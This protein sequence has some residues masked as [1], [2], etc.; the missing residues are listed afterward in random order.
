MKWT[1]NLEFNL[2]KNRNNRNPHLLHPFVRRGMEAMLKELEDRGFAPLMFEGWRHPERQ[3]KMKWASNGVVTRAKEWVSSHQFGLA[4]DMVSRGDGRKSMW[5]DPPFFKMLCDIAP[6][7]GLRQLRDRE[8]RLI[9]QCHVQRGRVPKSKKQAVDLI[10][11][12]GHSEEV[13]K[14]AATQLELAM[15]CDRL[16]PPPWWL[17][18][19]RE[20]GA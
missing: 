16:P 1:S 10:L 14:W 15:A 6:N 12:D 8:G 17:E 4:F 9:E 19:L 20:A 13:E 7:H 18:A 11:R 5:D 3:K 2:S